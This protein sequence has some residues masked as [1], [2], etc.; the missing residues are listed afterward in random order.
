[1]I[2]KITAPDG[3]ESFITASDTREALDRWLSDNEYLFDRN[4][5]VLDVTVEPENGLIETCSVYYE[6][7]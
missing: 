3:A 4:G 7:D 2:Y 6:G 1:M 5:S